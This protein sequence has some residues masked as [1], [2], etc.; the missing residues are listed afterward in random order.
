MSN[1]KRETINIERF[2]MLGFERF[3]LNVKN[4][5]MTNQVS[6]LF[7]SFCGSLFIWRTHTKYTWTLFEHNLCLISICALSRY[8]N[9][10]NLSQTL[11]V[12]WSNSEFV[13]KTIFVVKSDKN[14]NVRLIQM[15]FMN[16]S[17]LSGWIFSCDSS[18]I[19][20]VACH[21]LLPFCYVCQQ[22]VL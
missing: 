3:I 11:Q 1:N 17:C 8:Q 9:T 2:F 19:S 22:R 10:I 12:T 4:L 6:S 13:K 16:L 20:R 15:M 7:W 14:A 5:K 18:S 21:S